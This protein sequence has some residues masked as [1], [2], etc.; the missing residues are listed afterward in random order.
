MLAKNSKWKK[1]RSDRAELIM[2]DR[3]SGMSMVEIAVKNGVSRQR[4]Y[5]IVKSAGIKVNRGPSNK[6]VDTNE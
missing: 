5:Q 1:S 3:E 4:V 2:K 6:K